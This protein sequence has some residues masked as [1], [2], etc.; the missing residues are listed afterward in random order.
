MIAAFL[1]LLLITGGFPL[2]STKPPELN[3]PT[4]S[5]SSDDEDMYDIYSEDYFNE[6]MYSPTLHSNVR[7]CNKTY[8][9]LLEHLQWTDKRREMFTLTRPAKDHSK[10]TVI[11]LDVLLYAILDVDQTLR[12]KEQTFVSY[13]WVDML[14]R[15]EY[16]GWNRR[17]FC[18]IRKIVLPTKL[19]WK[20]DLTVEEM[21]EKD[22]A[23]QIPYLRLGSN[24]WILLRNDMVLTTTCRMQ[25]YKFPFDTQSCSLTFKS[26]LHGVDQIRFKLYGDSKRATD[27]TKEVM[28]SQSDWLFINITITNQTIV[29]FDIKQSVVVATITMK[30]RSI[31]YIVNFIVP[32]LLFLCLDLASFMISERGGEKLSF[33]VTVLLAVTVMQLILNE[34]LPS[35]SDRIPLI[36]IYCIGVF[37]LMLM[38][39]L[40]TIVVMYLLEKDSEHQD[41][42]TDADQSLCRDCNDKQEKVKCQNCFRDIKKWTHCL[43]PCD[44]SPG[45]MPSELLPVANEASSSHL[46]EDSYNSE[47]EGMKALSLPLSST[48]EER[49]TG[50]WERMTKKI[51][52]VFFIFHITSA[53]LF[54]AFM[55]YNWIK[56]D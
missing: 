24:G 25:V 49:Q 7:P 31:L 3:Q 23:T 53:S 47:K 11:L 33:K 36:A 21:T 28:K 8:Q 46:T 27:K 37:G 48:K 9:D 42:K 1:F 51:N 45:E 4:A 22:K 26:V 40:E 17:N 12:E 41:S 19:F 30:R 6:D 50:Y 39:L 55:S 2:N 35:S 52:R 38:S 5:Q 44:A 20:P 10:P 54:L 29:N 18:G 14:W 13:V 32:V 16:I 43:F 56:E 15:D 34:I